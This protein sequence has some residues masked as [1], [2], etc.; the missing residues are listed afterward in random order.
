MQ[1]NIQESDSAVRELVKRALSGEEITFDEEGTT[2]AK[3]IACVPSSRKQRRRGGQ[4]KGRVKI[5]ADFD[6]L[7]PEIAK[8]FGMDGE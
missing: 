8:A 3:L 4:W 1:I 6:E 5:A 2:V 7:P